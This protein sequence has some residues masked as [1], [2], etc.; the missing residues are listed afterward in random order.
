MTAVG[1]YDRSMEV[2]FSKRGKGVDEVVRSVC[3]IQTGDFAQYSS[4]HV[5]ATVIILFLERESHGRG[6]LKRRESQEPFSVSQ[7]EIH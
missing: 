4:V 7:I 3:K 1:S 2:V 6:K 5:E